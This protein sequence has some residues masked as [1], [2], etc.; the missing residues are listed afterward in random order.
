MD[1]PFMQINHFFYKKQTEKIESVVR[2]AAELLPIGTGLLG[3]WHQKDAHLVGR[4]TINCVPVK[5]HCRLT[6]WNFLVAAT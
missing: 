1:L 5:D 6:F 2:P 4:K 3:V